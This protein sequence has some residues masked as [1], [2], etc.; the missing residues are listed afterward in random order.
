MI[1]RH[2]PRSS[3]LWLW[4]PGCDE[5]HR[6]EVNTG[7]W[8]WDGDT[9]HP[10]V[11]PSILVGGVQWAKGKD[12]HKPQHSQV[13]A[14]GPIVCHSFVRGGRWEFLSD[15]THGL[16]GQTVDVVPLPDWLARD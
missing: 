5:A 13:V 10:T 4:C 15:S 2:E 9:E 16:A 1:V 8:T 3:S 6:I 12:F 14:G 7:K 11:S